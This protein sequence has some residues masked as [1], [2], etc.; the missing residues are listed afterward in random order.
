MESYKQS[1]EREAPDGDSTE[2]PCFPPTHVGWHRPLSSWF[3]CNWGTTF[4]EENNTWGLGVVVRDSEGLVV[5]AMLSSAVKTK[6]IN[7]GFSI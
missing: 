7:K 3:K 2:P 1:M 5:A 4:S 6:K